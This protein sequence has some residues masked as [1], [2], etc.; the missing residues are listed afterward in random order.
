MPLPI[1]LRHGRKYQHIL[2]AIDHLSKKNKF[3]L[4]DF[5]EVEIVI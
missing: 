1:F 4:L 2:A 3:I 5:L